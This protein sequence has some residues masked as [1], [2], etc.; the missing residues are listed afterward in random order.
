MCSFI[1]TNSIEKISRSQLI[2][3]NNYLKSRGPSHTNLINFTKYNLNYG[4]VH[5]LLDISNS[6]INQPIFEDLEN[7]LLFNGEIYEPRII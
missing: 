4:A 3:A 1:L 7:M 2:I 6:F 5:N